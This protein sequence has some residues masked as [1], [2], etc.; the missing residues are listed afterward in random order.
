MKHELIKFLNSTRDIYVSCISECLNLSTNTEIDTLLIDKRTDQGL[1]HYCY[2]HFKRGLIS[3][4][5]YKFFDRT[6][7]FFDENLLGQ[8][9]HRYPLYCDSKRKK[10]TALGKRIGLIDRLIIHLNNQ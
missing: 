7:Y 4:A 8:P 9:Y 6:L 3:A 5:L 1:C 2:V 10:I